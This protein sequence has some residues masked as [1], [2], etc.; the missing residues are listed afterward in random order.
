MRAPPVAGRRSGRTLL[1]ATIMPPEVY[2][3]ELVCLTET[4]EVG[5]GGEES[6]TFT[7]DFAREMAAGGAISDTEPVF[8]SDF[9]SL[10]HS[11]YRE[12]LVRENLTFFSEKVQQP[13]LDFQDDEDQNEESEVV[14]QNMDEAR[15]ET[16]RLSSI[17]K[18][19]TVVEVNHHHQQSREEEEELAQL[20]I[21]SAD[22]NKLSEEV[23]RLQKQLAGMDDSRRVYEAATK[24]LVSFLELV[25]NQLSVETML[26]NKQRLRERTRQV[27]FE[28]SNRARMMGSRLSDVG[29]CDLGMSDLSIGG[30][31][32]EIGRRK[33]EEEKSEKGK[34]R[35]TVTS[36]DS[37]SF[38]RQRGLRRR[39]VSVQGSPLLYLGKGNNSDGSSD[40][41][42]TV[43]SNEQNNDSGKDSGRFTDSERGSPTGGASRRRQLGARGAELV[44]QV[45]RFLGKSLPESSSDKTLVKGLSDRFV[46]TPPDIPARTLTERPSSTCTPIGDVKRETMSPPNN[47]KGK[48]NRNRVV[49]QLGSELP[50]WRGAV[51]QQERRKSF[52]SVPRRSRGSIETDSC[53]TVTV[54]VPFIQPPGP[55]L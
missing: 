1:G 53:G 10:V 28:R 16:I 7:S 44:R 51:R 8:K 36:G 19:E 38:R 33:K 14:Y 35:V 18:V 5:G 27:E 24:Q 4:E 31:A 13:N 21:T 26:E 9:A 41:N 32:E 30:S 15:Q 17:S 2:R 6:G 46:T 47:G 48:E 11:S 43:D 29:L 37:S 20:S 49:I 12:E 52:T 23:E 3:A 55:W 34:R 25:S 40:N 39:P 42:D 54:P 45:R 22:Y 50:G